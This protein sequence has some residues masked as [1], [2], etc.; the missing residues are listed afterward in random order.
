MAA[1]VVVVGGL[2]AIHIIQGPSKA[3]LSFADASTTSA[4]SGTPT[5]ALTSLD[6]S[7]EVAS[8]S[9]AGYRVKETLFGRSSTAVGRTNAITGSLTLT[10]TTVPKAS[11][12]VDMTKVSSDRS[13]RDGQFQGRIMDTA[14]FPTA[15]F[16]LTSPIVLGTIPANGVEVTPKATGKLMLHGTTKSV[17]FTVAAKRTGNTIQVLGSI[18]ITFAD[19]GI[20]NPSGGPASVGNNGTLEFLLVLANA[21]QRP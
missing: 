14:Q 4:A 12:T 20:S 6:G 18:P 16:T 13:I 8:G 11:F 15:T 10:G 2:V 19:Y 5:T 1:V 3:P 21:S 9:T 17:T 7:W